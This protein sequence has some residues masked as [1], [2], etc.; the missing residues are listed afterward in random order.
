MK[1]ILI[2]DDDIAMTNYLKVFL[3]QTGLYELVVVNDSRQVAPL[4]DKEPFDIILLDMVM[5]NVSGLDILSDIQTRGTD[6]QVVVLTGISDVDLAV[7]AMKL[8][9]FDYL[10]KPVDEEKLLEVLHNATK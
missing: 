6:T 10:I 3:T 8:G 5:P 2:M 7:N 9:A 1:K 4:L